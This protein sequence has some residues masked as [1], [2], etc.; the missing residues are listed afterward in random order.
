MQNLAQP[1]PPPGARR[2][3]SLFEMLVATAL[4]GVVIGLAVQGFSEAKKLG[5]MAR[6]RMVARQEAN[7]AVQKIAKIVRRSHIIF[8]DPRPLGQMATPET[9]NLGNIAR[10]TNPPE[11][12]LDQA[13]GDSVEHRWASPRTPAYITPF[14]GWGSQARGL[15]R[16]GNFN[17]PA[18]AGTTDTVQTAVRYIRT[19]ALL[20]A[21]APAENRFDHYFPSPLLYCAEAQFVAGRLQTPPPPPGELRPSNAQTPACP[22]P[23]HFIWCTWLRCDCRPP[24]MSPVNTACCP[25]WGATLP[26]AT[27]LRAAPHAPP[28]LSNCDS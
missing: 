19:A 1:A 8:F 6:A 27:N 25:W 13:A 3:F 28:F 17:L 10:D 5:D 15:F 12:L 20:A 26:N 21:G 16:A 4:V 23:G 2:G 7:G 24:R 18:G 9:V 11:F 22:F 14:T